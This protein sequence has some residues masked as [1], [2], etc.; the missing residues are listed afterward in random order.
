ME[1]LSKW[2]EAVDDFSRIITP[3]TTEEL[4]FV[5]RAEAHE[6]LEHWEL[7]AADWGNADLHAPDKKARHGNPSFPSLER[8]SHIHG[9]LGQWDKQVVDFTELLKPERLGDS[10]WMFA[11]RGD[12]YGQLRQSDKARA[13]HDQ[14]IKICSPTDRGY[15]QYRRGTY[16]AAQGQWKEA[17]DDMRLAYQ[18]PPD[19]I[20]NWANFRD[21]AFI[22]AMTGDVENYRKAAADCFSKQAT[23]KLS[24][25]DDRWIVLT[26]LQLPEM[27]T[28]ENRTR[29]LE[30]AAKADPY[31]QPRLTA[32][33]HFRGGEYEKAATLFDAND[34]GPYLLFLAAM[35]HQKLGHHDRAKQLL[36]QGNAWVRDQRAKD[37]EAGVPRPYGWQ[38][39]VTAVSLQREA[40]DVLLGSGIS[41]PK[42][43]ALLGQMAQAA[44]AYAKALADAAD[45][46]S[47][48]K[49]LA[50]LAELDDVLTE[51]HRRLPGD[52]P[53]QDAYRRMVDKAAAEFSRKI[54]ALPEHREAWQERSKL[55]MTVIRR[56]DGVFGSLMKLRPEDTLL[57]ICQARDY[58]C[59]SDW[60]NAAREYAKIVE[61][62]ALS[63]E[64]YEYAAVL[65]LAEKTPEYRNYMKRAAAKADEQ[66]DPF[67]A[68]SLA[69]AAAISPTPAV[70][71]KQAVEWAERALGDTEHAWY[72]HV[73]GLAHLRAG[74]DEQALK[75]LG[76]SLATDWHPE[77]NHLG[78]ALAYARR[79]ETARAREYLQLAQKWF[80][81]QESLK[82]DDY[83]TGQETDWLEAHL[84]LH[85]AQALIEGNKAT[86]EQGR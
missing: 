51:L 18:T 47:K 73:A 15:F 11:G 86:K 19:S 50:E 62:T 74:N 77:L 79:Q 20:K 4:L 39:W 6:K 67:I 64:W 16:F 78:L 32:A 24:A 71:P 35:T 65:L 36:E 45:L 30:L 55:V 2:Q 46:D 22:Y 52:S 33:L 31:W 26:M 56:R 42:K 14:A 59:K 84:L 5:R 43:L 8:R 21:A 25:D 82:K 27:I 61:T 57:Q 69:R 23:G 53:I 66:P 13:D 17:A 34:P 49:I 41:R 12:A 63:E 10:P 38:D 70:P 7:A 75:F 1:A 40:E 72:L 37:P 54:D 48:T 60:Q 83:Y 76:Q 44:D 80:Q 81:D 9:R 68:Y 3:Q 85:E 28:S 29:L 58:V